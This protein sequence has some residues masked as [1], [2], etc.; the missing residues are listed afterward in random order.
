MNKKKILNLRLSVDEI[1]KFVK[2]N[3]TLISQEGKWPS[4]E[5]AEA[6]LLKSLGRERYDNSRLWNSDHNGYFIVFAPNTQ[7]YLLKEGDIVIFTGTQGFLVDIYSQVLR[8]G[9]GC[10]FEPDSVK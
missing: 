5:E 4:F 1:Y 10:R 9:E 6:D 8:K 3:G 7:K 2:K